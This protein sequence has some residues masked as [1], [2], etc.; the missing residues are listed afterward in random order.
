MPYEVIRSGRLNSTIIGIGD[1]G[2]KVL[3]SI[4]NT[5]TV[6]VFSLAIATSEKHSCYRH[7]AARALQLDPNNCGPELRVIEDWLL[8]S[9]LNIF[10]FDYNQN[11]DFAIKVSHLLMHKDDNCK[12][13]VIVP[14]SIK[15]PTIKSEPLFRNFN[16]VVSKS[17]DVCYESISTECIYVSTIFKIIYHHT[18]I[19]VE[20]TDLI[21]PLE[22]KLNKINFVFTQKIH[23]SEL[24]DRIIKFTSCM[25]DNLDFVIFCIE[26][27]IMNKSEIFEIIDCV[28]SRR[29]TKFLAS[30]VH[31]N[32]LTGYANLT[33][34]G[35]EQMRW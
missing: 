23:L 30:I 8:E 34:I 14:P 15:I 31:N 6:N 7:P 21:E 19:G 17:H 20:Y 29:D 22:F 35:L 13:I 4:I 3:E 27:N 10:I 18:V 9:N 26:C 32:D 5:G 2:C 12:N 28:D 33:I 25:N 24:Q 1:Y 16:A 11:L